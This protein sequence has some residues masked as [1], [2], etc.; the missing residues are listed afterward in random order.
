[1]DDLEMKC[2]LLASYSKAKE[3]GLHGFASS[4]LNI[5]SDMAK[6]DTEK[7]QFENLDMDSSVFRHQRAS[8]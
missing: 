5:L 7:T 8:N 2:R 3:E 6:N 1:M 4:I